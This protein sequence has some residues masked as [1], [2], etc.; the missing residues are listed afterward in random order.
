MLGLH[1]WS[2]ALTL[3][4]ISTRKPLVKK[5]L[6]TYRA[7]Y[8]EYSPVVHHPGASTLRDNTAAYL[9]YV[10][11]AGKQDVDI[12]V[13]PEYGL[14]GYDSSS[15]A[16]WVS[17]G[18]TENVPAPPPSGERLI[19]CDDTSK[20]SDAPSIVALS[21]AARQHKVAVVVN[22]VT[23]DS[24]RD[25]YNTDVALDT[26]GTLI[27]RYHKLN[28]WGETNMGRPADCPM[29]S[30]TPSFGVT[31]GLI[32]CADLVYSFPTLG[33]RSWVVKS[34]VTDFVVPV[35][36]NNGWS[37]MQVMATAQGWSLRANAT[38]TVANELLRQSSGSG[39]WQRGQALP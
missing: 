31:F 29:T 15:R 34:G 38:L 25:M 32:T 21:C 33:L 14:T 23:Y 28:L 6:D 26:D 18:W 12:L 9:D 20:F 17:G 13:F 1:V 10:A 2:A 22:L 35:A 39:V 5:S 24:G 7:A 37:Q 30:F 36:W 19:P 8:V 3:D 4:Q 11:E 16:A 27:A